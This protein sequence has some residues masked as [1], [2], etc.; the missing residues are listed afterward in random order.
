MRHPA[1]GI[2]LNPARNEASGNTLAC[3][4]TTSDSTPESCGHTVRN[5][6]ACLAACYPGDDL[7]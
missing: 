5:N 3:L 4:P 1:P 2:P 7:D 6:F